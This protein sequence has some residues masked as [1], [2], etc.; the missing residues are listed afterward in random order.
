ME[1][2]FKGR[3]CKLD[4]DL[5]KLLEKIRNADALLLIAPTYVLSVPGSLKL[6]LDRYLT[7]PAFFGYKQDKPAISIGVAA[8]RDWHQFELPMLNLMLL[9]MGFRVR[10]SFVAYG[11]GPGEVLIGDTTEKLKKSVDRLCKEK[12]I[13]SFESQTSEHCPVDFSTVFE[14]IGENTYR[15]P[16]CLTPC[17]QRKN[18]FYFKADDLNNHRWIPENV[19]E[20]FYN[21]I[22]KTK[23]RFK[24]NLREIQ[25]KK[26]ELGI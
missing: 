19:R 4:D 11:S 17:E 12:E 6:L 13:Q 24:E 5:Y 10:D 18:G 8:L 22:S 16:V 14:R 25:K 9:C 3:L 20:H 15:C 26:K 1:C 2:V 7:M 21:W 23:N